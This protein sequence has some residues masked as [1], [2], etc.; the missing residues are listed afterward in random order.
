MYS[1]GLATIALCEAYGLSSDHNIGIA[2]QVAVNYI[3]AA[4]DQENAAGGTTPATRR[5]LGG[6]LADHGPEEHRWPA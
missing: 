5:H 4:Q 2:A 6:R 1:H 3:I